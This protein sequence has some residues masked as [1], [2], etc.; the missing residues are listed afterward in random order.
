MHSL[1]LFPPVVL[2][3]ELLQV[4]AERR[5]RWLRSGKR[6]FERVRAQVFT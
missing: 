3:L 4:W 5:R 2:I 1:Y 6:S